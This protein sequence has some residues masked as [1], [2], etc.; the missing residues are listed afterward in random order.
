MVNSDPL[1]QPLERL[2]GLVELERRLELA[3]VKETADVLDA[4][5]SLSS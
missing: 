5:G 3:E 2:V 1:L 4:R